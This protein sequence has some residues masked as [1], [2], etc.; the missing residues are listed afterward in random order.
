MYITENILHSNK[1]KTTTL[2]LKIYQLNKKILHQID[3]F[4]QNI[5]FLQ[6]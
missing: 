4:Y 6:P 2:Q 5:E 1:K 3:N